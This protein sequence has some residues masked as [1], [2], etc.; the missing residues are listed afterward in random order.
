MSNILFLV[1]YPINEAPSQR[2]RFEQYFEILKQHHHAYAV[3][4]FIDKST[5]KILYKP[6]NTLKKTLGIL[7]GFARRCNIL[8]RLRHFDYV[9][10]HREAS[11]I[12]PPI[13]EWFIA[14]VFRK[15]IIF[16]F[17]DAIWLPN[18]SGE[19]KIAASLKWHSKTASICKW[20]F[21]CSCGNDFLANY[22]RQFNANVVVNPTTIDLENYHSGKK[23]QL[24][25]PVKIGWTGTHTT[26]KYI[27]EIIPV[28]KKIMPTFNCSFVI[29][30]N[31]KP[32][33]NLPN[34]EFIP[35]KK[36]TEIQDLLRFHI[37]IMPLTDDDWSRGKCGFK[38]LQYMSL[39]I[40]AL[41]SPVGVNTTIVDNGK[42]GFLCATQSD[43]E[44]ALSALINNS[45]LRKQMGENAQHK[46]ETHFSVAA[47]TQNF[48][49]LFQP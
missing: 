7:A 44:Q 42:N 49:S 14:K 12:G 23:N 11:P 15:K 4:S 24:E 19:N 48:L 31:K 40:P 21:K 46:I 28:L 16:D 47:N 10:I 18:T 1:P 8:F 38:A 39:G 36:E 13:F 6:G 25:T 17:D 32:E 5:W 41:V 2:F 22:A 37:G 20:A 27:D 3:Q 29:I 34:L 33:I 30:S 35:W 45:D 26:L 43:W 9:F